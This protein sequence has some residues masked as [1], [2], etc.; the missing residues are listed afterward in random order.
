MVPKD[1][2]F[3]VEGRHEGIVTKKEFLKAQEI[4]NKMGEKRNSIPKTYPLYRKVKCGICGRVMSYRTYSYK[5]ITYRYFACL[6]A[7]EQIGE[8]GCCKRCVKEDDLNE[9]VWL[10][11]K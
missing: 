7:K 8:G 3:I 10:V 6:H 11:V 1:E 2:Q 4:F 5:D 9:I